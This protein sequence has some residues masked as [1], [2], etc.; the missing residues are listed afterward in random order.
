M[1]QLKSGTE[2]I[3][4]YQLEKTSRQWVLSDSSI[5]DCLD[6]EVD[7]VVL[8]KELFDLAG[9]SERIIERLRALRLLESELPLPQMGNEED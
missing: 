3:P 6:M 9:L 2:L 4:D 7:M 8:R 5:Q 1:N